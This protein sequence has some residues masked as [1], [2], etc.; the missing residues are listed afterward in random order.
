MLLPV[1]SERLISGSKLPD[2]HQICTPQHKATP[3]KFNTDFVQPSHSPDPPFPLMQGHGKCLPALDEA[4]EEQDEDYSLNKGVHHQ[5]VVQYIS[6]P[7]EGLVILCPCIASP[8]NNVKLSSANSRHAG[9][10]LPNGCMPLY[11]SQ[12]V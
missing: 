6:V 4:A 10:A 2:E 7:K 11:M 9:C 12:S 5:Q 8:Q 1:L 3:H